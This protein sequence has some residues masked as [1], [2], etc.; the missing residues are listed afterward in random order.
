MFRPRMGR[1]KGQS[2]NRMIP[3]IL[4]MLALCAGLTAFRFA[5]EQRWELAVLCILIAAVLDALDGRIARILKLS[6]RFGAELDS[7]SDFFAFGVAPSMLLYL[8]S[9]EQAGRVGWVVALFYSVCCALRLARFNTDIEAPSL[10]A[11]AKNY[12]TGVPSPA[13]AG[14]VLIPMILSFQLDWAVLRH[15][16]LVSIFVIAVALLMVSRLPTY[17]FKNVRV[18]HR[19][20]LVMMLMVALIAAFL[21]IAP[22]SLLTVLLAAYITTMPFAWQSFHRLQR[23]AQGFQAQTA[24]PLDSPAETDD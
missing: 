11:W 19:F 5:F 13:G 18:Q 24:P 2:F 6:S 8:W 14:L 4:T 15:P 21:V 9:L 20:A 1:L 10:P 12:F 23:E 3:N 17:S 16:I 22:W 7:L